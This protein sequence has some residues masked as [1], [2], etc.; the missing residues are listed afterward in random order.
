MIYEEI[1]NLTYLGIALQLLGALLLKD[2]IMNPWIGLMT[3]NAIITTTI[4][5][6]RSTYI[7]FNI[8]VLRLTCSQ[9]GRR[10]A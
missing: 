6:T 1:S 5:S 8:S 4:I 2:V 10:A 9:S 3:E 7:M